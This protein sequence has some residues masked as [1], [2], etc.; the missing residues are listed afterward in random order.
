VRIAVAVLVLTQCLNLVFVPYFRHAGLAL[1]IG[2]GAVVNAA[3]LFVGLRRAGWYQPAPGWLGFGL[4]VLIATA[5]LG[6]LLAWAA[7]A[8]DWLALGAHEGR[9][10][11]LMTACL[12]GAALVYFAALAALGIRLR[13]FM[14]RG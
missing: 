7:Q 10:I 13:H 8:F 5:L 4:K 1:S 12:A 14:R 6:G 9:R 11:G 2:L 3:W